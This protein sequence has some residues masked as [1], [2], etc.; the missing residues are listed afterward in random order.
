[1]VAAHSYT[2]NITAY[3]GLDSQVVQSKPS[4][5]STKR[6][7]G[8]EG[9]PRKVSFYAKVVV[10]DHIHN[11]QMDD[12]EHCAYWFQNYEYAIRR[13][14]CEETVILM[15]KGKIP[16]DDEDDGEDFCSRG[17]EGRTKAGR[18]QR[19]KS[20]SESCA[21]VNYEQNRQWSDVYRTSLDAT[22][23]AGAYRSTTEDAARLARRAGIRDEDYVKERSYFPGM[24]VNTPAAMKASTTASS[25]FFGFGGT[26]SSSSM[27]PSTFLTMQS[28]TSTSSHRR[29]IGA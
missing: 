20:R 14:E 18:R 8:G 29:T 19:T 13:A 2:Y 3:P 26:S 28:N 11:K 23:L 16:D 5:T 9:R 12:E 6:G 1:M 15:G 24:R 21:M 22:A 25:L 4:S 27:R 17:L 7:G 10:Y